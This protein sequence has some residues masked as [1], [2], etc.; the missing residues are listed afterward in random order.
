MEQQI[1]EAYKKKYPPELLKNREVTEGKVI[2]C[3]LRDMLFLDE[4]NLKS[5]DFITT[6]GRFFFTI[7]NNL[8]KKGISQVTELDM[9]ATFN[10]KVI[11]EFENKGG[12]NT[13]EHLKSI[14]HED[15]FY[16]Y[17]D[18]LYKKNAYLKLYDEGFNLLK[19]INIDGKEIIPIKL[20]EK[21][22]SESV[23]DFY[24]S[25]LT[26]MGIN[27]ISKG[28]EE[29]ELSIDDDFIENL[30]SGEES[31]VPFDKAG[32]DVNGDE[33]KCLPFTSN[34][35]QGFQ[36]ST[37]SFLS[38]F[39]STGK[40]TLY[41]N[42]LMSLIHRREKVLIIS[43]EQKSKPFKVGFISW[44][45]TNKLKYYKL[46]KKKLLSGSLN[47]E[48]LTMLRKA[49]AIFNSEY[50]SKIFFIATSDADM[51]LTKKKIR[52]YHLKKGVTTFLYDTFKLDSGSSANDNFW[53]QLIRD[54][55]E[56]DALAKK[57]NLIGLASMQLAINQ[58]GRLWLDS[59][60]LSMSKQVIEVLENLIQI[61]NVYPNE[62]DKSDKKYYCHPFRR[63]KNEGKWIEEEIELDKSKAYR[64]LFVTKCRSG[65]NSDSGNYAIILKFDGSYGNFTEICFARPKHAVIT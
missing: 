58:L 38:G 17:L 51:K 18:E 59:S 44:I 57:Y 34:I 9:R 13:L 24:E 2:A 40:S 4:I 14:V 64:M 6:D 61:R 42:I 39:S 19:S 45:L 20:F 30:L 37:L 11:E 65:E 47:E 22:D 48:E 62:L 33:I 23:V 3:L 27:T 35:L 54:S 52:E 43:N 63:V 31:G 12:I 7:L 55:R 16:T 10:D 1:F 8:R 15:N 46:T 49:Q 5:D 32:Y 50:K 36:P 28:T 21:M 29:M 56:L 25:R 41:I 60:C 53:L 26:E